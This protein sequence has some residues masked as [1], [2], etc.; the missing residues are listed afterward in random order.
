MKRGSSGRLLTPRNPPKI[1][2]ADTREERALLL[3]FARP[4]VKPPSD[5]AI[6]K[7]NSLPLQCVVH[8]VRLTKWP[9]KHV[10]RATPPFMTC[11]QRHQSQKE[12]FLPSVQGVKDDR[13]TDSR[14]I[15]TNDVGSRL[16][17]A[18]LGD[19]EGDTA[20]VRTAAAP[21][22]VGAEVCAVAAV[23]YGEPTN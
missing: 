4:A 13:L 8:S 1:R 7:P 5:A 2:G 16:S 18:E 15:P 20:A 12:L 22:W 14:I 6:L 19:A 9:R 23:I 10:V 3:S 11:C 17:A 21:L